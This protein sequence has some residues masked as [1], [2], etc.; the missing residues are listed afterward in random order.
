M[1]DPSTEVSCTTKLLSIGCRGASRLAVVAA[2]GL[3]AWTV[4]GLPACAN[5]GAA[6]SGEAVAE[7]GSEGVP[8]VLAPK[9][10]AD[11]APG[12][13]GDVGSARAGA[14]G[15]VADCAADVPVGDVAAG[16]A[17]GSSGHPINGERSDVPCT[18]WQPHGY[19]QCKSEFQ[20]NMHEH[21]QH[22]LRHRSCM[23]AK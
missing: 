13:V 5:A 11:E 12:G 20:N 23:H 9:G 1:A 4:D 17:N 7:V 8:A 6:P 18:H 3:L 10:V 16:K 21:H 2:A 15:A 19:L 22:Q 14:L